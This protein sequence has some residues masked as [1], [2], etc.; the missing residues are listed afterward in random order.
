METAVPGPGVYAGSGFAI[1]DEHTLLH[2]AT[3]VFFFQTVQP[4][5]PS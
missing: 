1:T 4:S 2:V 5:Q 3:L